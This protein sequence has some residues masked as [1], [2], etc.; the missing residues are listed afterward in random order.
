MAWK[1]VQYHQCEHVLVFSSLRPLPLYL[2]NKPHSPESRRTSCAESTEAQGH[3]APQ[4]TSIFGDTNSFDS[5]LSHSHDWTCCLADYGIFAPR[6]ILVQ[7][8]LNMLADPGDLNIAGDAPQ[9][10]CSIR[11][12]TLAGYWF[13][14]CSSEGVSFSSSRLHS[15]EAVEN[16]T[17][18]RLNHQ[19]CRTSL[20]ISHS[21]SSCLSVCNSDR[22]ER[23][24]STHNSVYMLDIM[25]SISTRLASLFRSSP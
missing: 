7:A 19:P 22:K 16:A 13:S 12:T 2:L 6:L 3:L 9:V 8:P 14:R 15:V 1:F 23:R 24:P 18:T 11:T 4:L 21:Y 17:A 5:S 25:G 20:R 10:Y